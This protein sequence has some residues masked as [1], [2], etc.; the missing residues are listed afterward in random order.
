MAV[1]R[2]KLHRPNAGTHDPRFLVAALILIVGA[3]LAHDCAAQIMEVKA[4]LS[5]AQ[6]YID[7]LIDYID[8]LPATW[9]AP[10]RDGSPGR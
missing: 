7:Q 6:Q 9:E 4:R 5:Q 8:S 1:Q 3:L 10:T 2:R